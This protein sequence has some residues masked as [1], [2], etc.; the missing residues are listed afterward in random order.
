M[1]KKEAE[2]IVSQINEY[3]A[4]LERSRSDRSKKEI[5]DQIGNLKLYLKENGRAISRSEYNGSFSAWRLV[6]TAEEEAEIDEL[7]RR[8]KVR[9]YMRE[10]E[11]KQRE[12]ISNLERLQGDIEA[13]MQ[14]CKDGRWSTGIIPLSQRA[15]EIEKTMAEIE[16]MT[17]IITDVVKTEDLSEPVW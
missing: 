14:R 1:N 7:T 17:K 3:E 15:Q 4:K 10:I 13:Q 5:A 11:Y 8:Y 9:G 12:V 6:L 2:A 16:M